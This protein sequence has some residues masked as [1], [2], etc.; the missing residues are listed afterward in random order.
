MN[1][2]KRFKYILASVLLIIVVL[3]AVYLNQKRTEMYVIFD[4]DFSNCTNVKDSYKKMFF[5]VCDGDKTILFLKKDDIPSKTKNIGFLNKLNIISTEELFE[6]FYSEPFE[7]DKNNP[8]KV[9]MFLIIKNET[10]K[11][12]EIIPV[13]IMQDISG[14]YIIN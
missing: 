14:G 2:I 3:T 9:N 7:S 12:I 5:V 10:S 4:S 13:R 1:K 6:K 11:Q 8:K